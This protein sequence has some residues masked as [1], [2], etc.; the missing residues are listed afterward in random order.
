MSLKK[1]I[2]KIVYRL[3]GE[4]TLDTLVSMGLTVGNNVSIQQGVNL[5]PSHCW[6]ITIGDDVTLAPRVQLLAHDASTC[7]HIGY[8]KI[9]KVVIGNRVF[10]G[11]GTVILPDVRIGNDVIIGA[12]SVVTHSLEGNAVYAGNPAKKVCSLDEYVEKHRNKMKS[13]PVYGEEFTLR[14]NISKE[15]KAQQRIELDDG[16]GYVE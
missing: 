11:A 8:A 4:L 12:G 1:L 16:I 13:R 10:V 9:G 6:L 3:R 5:D 14:Q 2:Q 15:L 7:K